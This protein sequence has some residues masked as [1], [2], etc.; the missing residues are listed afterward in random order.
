[1]FLQRPYVLCRLFK[2]DDDSILDATDNNVEVASLSPVPCELSVVELKP[3]HVSRQAE[4]F[5]EHEC[6]KALVT[7]E[8]CNGE[9]SKATG[10]EP[11][12]DMNLEYL[13]WFLDPDP[14]DL[15]LLE[16]STVESMGSSLPP[17]S[18]TDN[19]CINGHDE[20]TSD[21]LQSIL[22]DSLDFEIPWYEFMNQLDVPG[23]D[24]GVFL[25]S[26]SENTDL[27]NILP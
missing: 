24:S 7:S 19:C 14:N 27:V 22:S 4:S 3:E 20:F 8:Y 5:S 23:T 16:S 10:Q 9:S 11:L 2:K 6:E 17:H 15:S 13:K 21:V 1:M 18:A 26:K 12:Q 25:Q